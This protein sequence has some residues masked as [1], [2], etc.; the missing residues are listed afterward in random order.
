LVVPPM[1]SP[2]CVPSGVEATARTA[3][4]RH[5]TVL[6]VYSSCVS[7]DCLRAPAPWQM[8]RVPFTARALA[9]VTIPPS[10][11]SNGPRSRARACRI[12]RAAGRATVSR[13]YRCPLP[14]ARLAPRCHRPVPR[15][16]GAPYRPPLPGGARRG[17]PA[18][19]RA[20]QRRSAVS[21]G[22]ATH[23][24]NA[25]AAF[26]LGANPRMGMRALPTIP[27]GGGRRGPAVS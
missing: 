15:C 10:G 27:S 25:M 19:N 2:Q 14:A 16:Q 6:L 9:A 8:Y 1:S 17:R 24:R 22:S 7:C 11:S 13:L 21:G 26:Q 12:P 4:T 5:V 20:G 23:R 3:S 18:L